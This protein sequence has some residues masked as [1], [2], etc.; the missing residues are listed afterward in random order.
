VSSRRK[1]NEAPSEKVQLNK[2][3]LI[4]VVLKKLLPPGQLAKIEKRSENEWKSEGNKKFHEL[5]SIFQES[6]FPFK[7]L[8]F[9]FEL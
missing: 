8:Q 7:F 9:A 2:A 1:I 6:A 4:L 3:L 5:V